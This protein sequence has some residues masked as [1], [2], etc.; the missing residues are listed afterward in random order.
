MASVSETLSL[1]TEQVHSCIYSRDERQ[2]YLQ[3]MAYALNAICAPRLPCSVLFFFPKKI[4]VALRED[5]AFPFELSCHP[6]MF[7]TISLQFFSLTFSLSA[8]FH[9]KI[10][11]LCDTPCE[12]VNPDMRNR[13]ALGE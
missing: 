13:F 1:T 5:K 7:L 6:T 12:G 9:A 8:K 2:I 10:S 11:I 4:F 3:P